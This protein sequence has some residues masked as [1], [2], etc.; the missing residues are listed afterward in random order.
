MRAS[1]DPPDTDGPSVNSTVSSGARAGLPE[2]TRSWMR[3][4][5]GACHVAMTRA[6]KVV[7]LAGLAD[8]LATMLEAPSFDP[9]DAYWVGAHLATADFDAPEALGRSVAVLSTLLL[10]ALDLRG[11][12][13]QER[14]TVI[15]Q[16]FATGFA[17]TLRDRTLDA[18]E[19]IRLAALAAHAQS[20]RELRES[21]RRFRHAALHDALTGLPNRT[22]FAER[23][24][25][26]FDDPP[27]PLAR[28]GVCFIDLDGFEGV[29][30]SLGPQAGD[31]LLMVVAQ[32]LRALAEETG[33]LVA[34][35]GDDEF[36]IL[37]EDTTCADDAVKVADR[38]LALIGDPCQLNG[39]E[40]PVSAKIGVVE[41]SIMETDP[42]DLMR[43]ADMTLHWAKADPKAKLTIFD[44]KRNASDV[45]RYRL[46]AEMP[47]ALDRGEFVLDYQ[48]LVG[49]RG[50]TLVGL[51]ALAR[52]RH[53]TLGLL[54]PNQFIA[55][56]EGTG[57]IVPLGINLLEQACRQAAGWQ[58]LGRSRPY[59]SVNLAVGQLR[60]PGLAGEVAAILDRT[61]LDPGLLQLEITESA[62]I[63]P[64]N[65]A[66]T[67]TIDCLYAL[68]ELGIKIAIDDFG[69]GYSNLTYLS[70][71]PI[72][73]I[74]LDRSFLIGPRGRRVDQA[75][76]DVVLQAAVSL[77]RQLG[78]TV[79]AEGVEEVEQVRRLQM[80]DCDAGQG[81]HFGRPV[82]PELAAALVAEDRLWLAGE[83][84]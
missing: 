76:S 59:V 9:T 75:K 54:G 84:R 78:L 23:L 19:Q 65:E 52:W 81:W 41:Q 55:L 28:L 71:L 17:R 33:H 67:A 61:G 38:A 57:L 25:Q 53:P 37:I 32:R 42:T 24:A 66:D 15:V 56:A 68:A 3:A 63:D 39:L 11:P 70:A 82:P 29:N 44:Q 79:T 72:H 13:V 6:E 26:L 50:G 40:L 60:Y 74:K 45:A 46:S 12:A 47:A 21:E 83:P 2:F 30:N 16:D 4:V 43:S 80:I 27:S 34:R 14:L 49:F 31:A 58:G 48:P 1:A 5:N 22:R 62:V 77:G 36:V 64:D 10:P 7:F 69:T 18:Q 20:E 73:A 35:L 51:E 8:R